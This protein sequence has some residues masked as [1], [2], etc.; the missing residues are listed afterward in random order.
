M[1]GKFKVGDKVI[2]WR[3]NKRTPKYIRDAIRMNRARTIV[4][5]YYDKEKEHNNYHLG[6]NK[7]G[8]DITVYPFRAEELRLAGTQGSQA[9]RRREKRIYRK[10]VDYTNK[11][12]K[13]PRY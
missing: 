6:S 5:I 1:K 11:G 3:L 10:H 12:G 4:H 9:G 2:V 8:V 13:T 7:S